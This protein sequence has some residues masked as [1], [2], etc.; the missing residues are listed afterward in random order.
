[1]I[2]LKIIL[3]FKMTNVSLSGFD[4]SQL[5]KPLMIRTPF[6][7]YNSRKPFFL[8]KYRKGYSGWPKSG[9]EKVI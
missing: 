7:F 1:M 5:L 4:A 8:S 2:D 9:M 6:T 3:C